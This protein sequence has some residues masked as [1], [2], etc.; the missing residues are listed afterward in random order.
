MLLLASDGEW[1]YARANILLS[2][3][4]PRRGLARSRHGRGCQPRTNLMKIPENGKL[5]RISRREQIMGSP[6]VI[7]GDRRSHELGMAGATCSGDRWISER[8]AISTPQ[9]SC[10]S[11]RSADDYRDR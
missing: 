7:G 11:Q 2:V 4:L 9:R 1:L 5:L 8:T 3:V 6:A 10:D